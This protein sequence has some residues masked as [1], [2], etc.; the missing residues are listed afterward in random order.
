MLR[1]SIALSFCPHLDT[2]RLAKTLV[3]IAQGQYLSKHVTFAS[4]DLLPH[5]FLVSLLPGQLNILHNDLWS[6]PACLEV[7]ACTQA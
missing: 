3:W 6:E 5:E 2:K 4:L 1:V 7:S